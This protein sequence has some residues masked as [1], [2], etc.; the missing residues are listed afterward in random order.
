MMKRA[1][2]LSA[3]LLLLPPGVRAQSDDKAYCE[4]L[5]VPINRYVQTPYDRGGAPDIEISEAINQ[6]RTGEPA[7]GIPVLE[8]KLR[9]NG[10][11]LP[12]R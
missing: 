11:T 3:L 5:I 8:R 4:A 7:K 2:L 10:F 12:K 1:L 9:N 6:C